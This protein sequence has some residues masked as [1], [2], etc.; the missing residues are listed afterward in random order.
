MGADLATWSMIGPMANEGLRNRSRRFRVVGAG[1]AVVV[2]AAGITGLVAR[3]ASADPTLPPLSA[4]ELLNRVATADVDGLSATFAQRSDLGLPAL[5][6][7]LGEDGE[8]W[9]SALAMLTGEHTIRVWQAGAERSRV[10]LVDGDTESSI[11]RNGRELWTWSSASQKAGHATIDSKAATP[12]PSGAPSTP[13]EAVEKV[14]AGIEPSTEV[15]TSG[16][17]YV[18]GR[19]VYQLVLTPRDGASLVGQLRVSVDAE[20]FVPLGLRVLDRGGADAITFTATT[21]D[22]AVPADTIFAFTPPPGVEVTELDAQRPAKHPAADRTSSKT[23]GSGWTTVAV[24]EVGTQKAEP[25]MRTLLESLPAV[26]GSWGSGR[27]LSTSLVNV[28]LTDDGR[29]AIGS[30]TEDRL[31]AALAR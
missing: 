10:S 31:Y 21:V 16:T 6:S 25:A 26:S 22:F 8:D 17:G 4:S 24:A 9:Q 1:L 14:L 2:A 3:G 18:A 13:A 12:A 7:G 5:P 15:T 20:K 23:F 27:L 30:V 19:P 28:V 29:I 11:I